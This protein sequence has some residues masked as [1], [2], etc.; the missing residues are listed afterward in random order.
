MAQPQQF[1][2]IRNSKRFAPTREFQ[3]IV[4]MLAPTSGLWGALRSGPRSL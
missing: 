3:F 2:R 4:E 1:T